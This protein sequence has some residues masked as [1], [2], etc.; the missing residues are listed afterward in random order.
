MDPIKD[1]GG[2]KL[3]EKHSRTYTPRIKQE[4]PDPKERHCK[5]C[6]ETRTCSFKHEHRRFNDDHADCF[7]RMQAI[8]KRRQK[9]REE[10]V[11][12]WREAECFGNLRAAGFTGTQASAILK[13]IRKLTYDT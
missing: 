1:E 9:E 8:E 7:E 10:E 13:T 3:Q 5:Y 12:N 4:V 2:T 6:G 11:R